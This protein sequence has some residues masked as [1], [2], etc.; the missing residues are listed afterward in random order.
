MLLLFKSHLDLG[1]WNFILKGVDELSDLDKELL[2][3]SVHKTC[4]FQVWKIFTWKC[5]HH[6]FL[7]PNK[8]A[9]FGKKT[10]MLYWKCNH[11]FNPDWKHIICECPKLNSY[12]NQISHFLH[13]IFTDKFYL[14]NNMIFFNVTIS[15][16]V[17]CSNHYN[18]WT[19]LTV[20]RKVINRF[21]NKE[22]TPQFEDF[23]LLLKGDIE[24][25]ILA[26]KFRSNMRNSI[27][28]SWNPVLQAIDSFS[29]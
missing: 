25:D 21:W 5:L 18:L 13:I 27:V 28:S 15:S 16:Q 3:Q 11:I 19:I 1:Y 12:W 17:K 7:T 6:F 2:L 29:L 26:V 20:V 23:V 10:D 9:N 14:S 8:L 24:K 4:K 22:G